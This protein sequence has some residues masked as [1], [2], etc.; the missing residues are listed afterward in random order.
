VLERQQDFLCL[1]DHHDHALN[2]ERLDH[3][4][5]EFMATYFPAAAPWERET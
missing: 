3:T 1:A 4:L 5:T 2:R